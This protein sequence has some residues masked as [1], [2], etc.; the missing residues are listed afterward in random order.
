M[1]NASSAGR[2]H[3]R[4]GEFDVIQHRS[5][6]EAE[7]RFV[8]IQ[9]RNR[10]A[11]EARERRRDERNVV[12]QE[13]PAA[14]PPPPPPPRPPPQPRPP[15]LQRQT[16]PYVA[17]ASCPICAKYSRPRALNVNAIDCVSRH[18]SSKA[19]Q[20]DVLHANLHRALHADPASGRPQCP[21]CALSFD[22]RLELFSHLAGASDAAH[23]ACRADAATIA[24]NTAGNQ[25]AADAARP[26]GP[27]A[28]TAEA[29][30]EVAAMYARQESAEG[31]AVE[32]RERQAA[33]EA[34]EEAAR[35]EEQA[36]A[37]AA[38]SLYA[39]AKMGGAR[40]ALWVSVHLFEHRVDPNE[41]RD[42]G[43]T[44]LMTASEAGHA[45]VVKLLRT[46]PDLQTTLKNAYGQAALHFAAQNNRT[47]VVDALL[48]PVA[49]GSAPSDIEQKA[50][51]A[52]AAEIARRAGH[53]DLA[54]SLAQRAAAMQVAAIVRALTE[55][56]QAAAVETPFDSLGQRLAALC[57]GLDALNAAGSSCHPDGDDDAYELDHGLPMC[58]V[59]LC[60]P[61]DAALRPCFHAG[62]C[63]D[64]A[65]MLA[66]RGFACPICRG[67]VSGVQRI[68]L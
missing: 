46:H 64:C 39:A 42:D 5:R 63:E 54:D 61:V 33:E 35:R 67:T 58:S 59:C 66:R 3:N 47:A 30:A 2:H 32:E 51:G 45:D 65:G 23:A 43:F 8:D 38:A 49:G 60:K 48:E 62:F 52:T 16:T 24:R 13:E 11:A 34:A 25:G 22:N 40:G 57:A 19:R 21:C 6:E 9:Q 56:G 29:L 1:G 36:E 14:P 18:I 28:G 15:T 27:R 10:E 31:V 41:Q 20:N 12:L 4:A 53:T 50:G 26:D 37:A 17:I 7:A 68:Y 44:P 55:S